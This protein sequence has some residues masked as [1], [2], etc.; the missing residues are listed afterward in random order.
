MIV[1]PAIGDVLMAWHLKSYGF[2]VPEGIRAASIQTATGYT[3][4]F[5]LP[6]ESFREIHGPFRDTV[7]LDVAVNDA[8]TDGST[9]KIFWKGNGDDWQYPHNF[10]PV[11]LPVISPK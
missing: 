10:Q 6:E 9:G 1:R 11:S 8:D 7:Y 3:V 2:P 5:F 4:Q